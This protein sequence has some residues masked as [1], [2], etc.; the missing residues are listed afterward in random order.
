MLRQNVAINESALT[1]AEK[2]GIA[3]CRMLDAWYDG[4]SAETRSLFWSLPRSLRLRILDV[5]IMPACREV[6]S[7]RVAPLAA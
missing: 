7:A 6:G 2:D 3:A 5:V 1:V 4:L